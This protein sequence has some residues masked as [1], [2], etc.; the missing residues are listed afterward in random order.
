M[1]LRLLELA[2]PIPQT[3]GFFVGFARYRLLKLFSKLDE[4]G[5]RLAVLRQP[6]RRFAA[7]ADLSVDVFQQRSQFTSEF[8]VVVRAA[9]TSGIT[10]LHELGAAYRT[11]AL[12]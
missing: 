5:L 7:V 4:L 10:E 11:L 8:F 2:N 3:G 9:Q 6:A 12:V 1:A